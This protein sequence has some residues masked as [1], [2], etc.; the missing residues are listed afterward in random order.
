K[1][2][3][4]V[5]QY[6]YLPEFSRFL[7]DH[8]LDDVTTDLLFYSREM[9]VPVLKFFQH[10]SETEMLSMSKEPTATFLRYL[11]AGK[12]EQQ[13]AESLDRWVSNQLGVVGKYDIVAED[14]TL[15]NY[16]RGKVFK[17]WAVKFGR[18][19]EHIYCIFEDIDKF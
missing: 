2:S 13:I 3:S 7:L 15:I 12:A 18:D 17:K 14:I 10:L 9:N 5:Y 1:P 19:Q 8:H 6:K 11:A 16:V 4:E